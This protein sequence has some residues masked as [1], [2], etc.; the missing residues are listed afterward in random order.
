MQISADKLK[1]ALPYSSLKKI[2]AKTGLS[3]RT[4]LRFKNPIVI[5]EALNIYRKEV[6]DSQKLCQ[7]INKLLNSEE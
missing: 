7:E 3:Y 6:R 4:V 5:R 2:A 1:A